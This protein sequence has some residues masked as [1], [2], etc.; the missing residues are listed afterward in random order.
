MTIELNKID[1][2]QFKVT[3]HVVAGE[4]MY[5]VQPQLAGVKW[6]QENKI[7]RSSLWNSTGELVSGSYQKFVN[8]L[9]N[10]EHFPI[11]QS[12]KNT[13]I[14]EKVDGS[15]CILSSYKNNRI[16]RTRGTVDATKLENGY[17]LEVF[18]QKYLPKIEAVMDAPTWDM[19]FIFEWVTA[20]KD[21]KIILTYDNAPE[22]YLTGIVN[23]KDYSLL[24]QKELDYWAE[25][26]GCPRPVT[27]TFHTIEE[28]LSNVALWKG[29]EGVVIYS[30]K[31][32]SLHKVKSLDY[33]AKHRFKSDATLEN[34]LD[35]FFS[36]GKPEYKDFEK[37]LTE[38]FDYECFEMVRGFISQIC[39]A[40]KDVLKI[41]DGM[42]EF[43]D[44]KLKLL[45]NRKEQAALVKSSYG[46]TS[47]TG[48]VFS[49]LDG[50]ALLDEQLKKLFWRI[51][52]K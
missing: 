21:H 16:L 23:H 3:E 37:K 46:N 38:T 27:Y 25:D 6:T 47:R 30:N 11:P 52:K 24:Q 14:V 4:V 28:L 32:Q 50:K 12:L 20:D 9:E 51:L 8:W 19:S 42:Q 49:L 34:T 48:F 39:D 17:E 29:K 33:L 26:I 5:L 43:I 22:W 10:P 35:L 1:R 41:I 40:Y 7:F 18:K 2:E 13:T 31:G 44:T 36:M 15:C 45:P